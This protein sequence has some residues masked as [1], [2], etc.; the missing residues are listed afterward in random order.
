MFRLRVP[1]GAL[2]SPSVLLSLR[3]TVFVMSYE[4]RRKPKPKPS[5]LETWA[6]EDD[7][8]AAREERMEY[9]R[10]LKELRRLTAD[11]SAFVKKKE[12]QEAAHTEAEGNTNEDSKKV[13][14]AL[15]APEQERTPQ[16]AAAPFDPRNST[17]A[18]P[19]VALPESITEKLGLAIKYLVSKE[20]QNWPLVVHQLRAAGGFTDVPERDIRK[21]VYA[22]PREQLKVVYPQIED[23]LEEAGIQKSPKLVNTYMKSLVSG[24]TV[25][26]DTLATVEECVAF[27][28]ENNKKGKLSRET[29]EILV[30]TYGKCNNLAKVNDII[31]EMTSRKMPPSPQVYSNVLT[32]CVYKAKDH[33]QA[34]KLFDLMKFLLGKTSPGTREYQDI[35]VSYVHAGDIERALD[36]YQE[37][38]AEKFEIN[39]SILVALARGC[40]SRDALKYKAWDFIFEIYNNNWEPT[41]PSVEYMIYLAAKDGDVSLARALYQQLNRSDSTT[42]RSFSFL[43]LAYS[44]FTAVDE[45]QPPAISFHQT[46]RI[47]RRNIVN[48]VD[49]TP[50]MDNPKQAVPYLPVRDLSSRSEI[51][52]ESSAVMAHALMM[53]PGYVNTESANTFLNIAA[54]AG[55]MDD[56]V[57]RLEQFTFLDK[58][59]I[60]E[61]RTRIE[62]EILEPETALVPKEVSKNK[63]PILDQVL[64]SQLVKVPRTT[65]TYLIALKAAGK[66]RD[67]VFAQKMWLE[68]GTFRKS[69]NFSNLAR[70]EKDKLD[71][72][73]AGAMVNCLTEM[74]LLDDALAILVSTEYQFKW[75]WKELTPLH[76]AAVH[77]GNDKI[78]RTVRG[79]AKRA[80][81]NFAG[82][83]RRK[84]YKQYV[85]ERGY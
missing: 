30:E 77:V 64:K 21:L 23:L 29:Y 80:Q 58:S 3:R 48:M 61:T 84:D 14:Q 70:Q 27:L 69:A 37:M 9:T 8:R 59:G 18:S 33:K 36:L 72:D 2:R 67:Y 47:F 32:T 46:G 20:T 85:R 71:F 73:F 25:D 15:E 41:L 17:L 53:H 54:N 38:L 40:T 24:N 76:V 7:K 52:A 74:A 10:R 42:A 78:T 13:Y 55:S 5:K 65:T 39:Q 79:I 50:P 82:K 56:F 4:K 60:S 22:I 57:E 34:V 45:S 11:V 51:L 16:L 63:S 1:P 31:Q 26:E 62:P 68:R 35:I 43:M 66:H 19:S 12:A 83:I 49:F 75:T 6:Q 44:K 28:K 81:I